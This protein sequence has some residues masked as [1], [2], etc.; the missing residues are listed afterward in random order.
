MNEMGVPRVH[1]VRRQALARLSGRAEV[2]D[3][4]VGVRTEL[5]EARAAG[6]EVEIDHSAALAG[7]PV[8]KGERSVGLRP[9]AR[10]G[11]AQAIRIAARRLDLDH[12][13]A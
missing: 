12:V 3:Q 6:L 2:L 9:I 11:P 1:L 13:R 7:I 4:D 10:E 8:E 5:L